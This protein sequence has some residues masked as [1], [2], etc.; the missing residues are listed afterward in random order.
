MPFN[1]KHALQVLKAVSFPIMW[2]KCYAIDW[3]HIAVKCGECAT[4]SET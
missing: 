1:M 3:T 4:D 2:T